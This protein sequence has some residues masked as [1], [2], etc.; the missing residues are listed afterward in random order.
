MANEHFYIKNSQLT[1][2]KVCQFMPHDPPL[3]G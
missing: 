2:E 1:Q 3:N